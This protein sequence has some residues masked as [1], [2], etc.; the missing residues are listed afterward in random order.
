MRPGIVHRLD[1][2]TTVASLGPRAR[3]LWCACKHRSRS[4]SPPASTWRWTTASLPPIRQGT[5]IAPIGRHP[6]DRKK[7]AV[8]HDDSGSHACTHWQVVERLADFSL[9]RFRLDT[10]RT[11]QV[12]VH[13]AHMNHPIVFGDD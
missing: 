1:K 6:A 2:D 4:E 5:I 10:G 12:H 13:C 8:V 3:R 11:H 9:L 7:Y